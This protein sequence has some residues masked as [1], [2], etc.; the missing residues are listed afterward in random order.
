MPKSKFLPKPKGNGLP[1]TIGPYPMAPHGKWATPLKGCVAPS[2]KMWKN[3][4]LNPPAG[5]P[6]QCGQECVLAKFWLILVLGA[7]WQALEWPPKAA[8]FTM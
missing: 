6:G 1:H 4:Y 7:L 2:A 5:H 3:P 8:W